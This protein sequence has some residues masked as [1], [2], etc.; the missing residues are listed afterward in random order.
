MW[1]SENKMHYKMYKAGKHWMYSAI[2]VTMFSVATLGG[3]LLLNNNHVHADTNSLTQGQKTNIGQISSS[4]TQENTGSD[5]KNESAT[6]DTAVTE[7]KA[8]A[9]SKNESVANDNAAAKPEEQKQSAATDTAATEE[10]AV[11]DSKNE[12]VANDNAAVKSKEQKQAASTDTAATEEKAGTDS[13]NESAANDNAA[14]KPEEQKQPVATTPAAT[15]EKAGTDSKNESVA[16]DNAAAKPEEQKQLVA[17]IPAATEEKAVTDSKN[18]SATSDNTAAKPEEQKQSAATD[19]T[20]AEEK[21][22]T[23]SNNES[24]TRDNTATKSEA[25]TQAATD[26]ENDYQST[27]NAQDVDNTLESDKFKNLEVVNST[28]DDP[29]NSNVTKNQNVDEID[30]SYDKAQLRLAATDTDSVTVTT[31]QEFYDALTKGTAPTINVGANIDLSTLAPSAGPTEITMQNLRDNVV[32]Q[33]TPG[34]TYTVDLGPYAF[35]IQNSNAN[36]TIQNLKAFGRSYYGIIS[37]AGRYDL[38]NLDYTGSQLIY[39]PSADIYIHNKVTSASVTSYNNGFSGGEKYTQDCTPTSVPNRQQVIQGE[40]ITFTSGST[41]DASTVNGNVIELSSGGKGAVLEDN[42][43][44][45]LHPHGANSSGEDI[46]NGSA[47]A[48]K[49]SSANV[50]IGKNAALNIIADD[51]QPADKGMTAGAIYLS[52]TSEINIADNG[53]LNV[54]TDGQA[55]SEPI[56]LTNSSTM[57]VSDSSSFTYNGNNL[58]NYTGD[59]IH[60]DG[61]GIFSISQ[62]GNFQVNVDGNGKIQVF[63]IKN[64]GNFTVDHPGIFIVDTTKNT[65]SGTTML[66]NGS[67]KVTNAELKLSDGS[68]SIPIKSVTLYFQNGIVTDVQDLQ[69]IS[70]SEIDNFIGKTDILTN[71][72]DSQQDAD[73]QAIISTLKNNGNA[74]RVVEFLADTPSKEDKDAAINKLKNYG[75]AAKDKIA[76][77]PGLTP[78]EISDG[79]KEVDDAVNDGVNNIESSQTPEAMMGS[80]KDGETNIDKIVDGLQGTSDTNIKNAKQTASD[81]VD[82]AAKDAIDHINNEPNLTPDEKKDAVNKVTD[83]ANQAKD[84]INNAGSLDDI[85]KAADDGITKITNDQNAADLQNAKNEAKDELAKYGQATKDKIAEIPGLTSDQISSADSDI[86]KEVANGS[87][88]IDNASDIAGVK[89][90]LTTSEGNIDKIVD[91]QNAK[92]KAK[93]E[94]VNYGQAAKDKIAKMPGL[95]SDQISSADAAIDKEVANGSANIDNASDTAGVDSAL[96]TSEGNID[97]IVDS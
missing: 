15:E 86:D 33:S 75:Q 67:L 78:D 16:N 73:N 54:E 4:I 39:S 46:S 96:T 53:K 57:N 92:N 31:A 35:R 70:R 52:G 50:S 68:N 5:S 12:S 62:N 87:A 14:A 3:T 44:V 17:T 36:V 79:Q 10:K 13:K 93:G 88:N 49:A 77:M 11:T 80:L 72:D 82:N 56:Y 21:A 23:D 55:K 76:N 8:V 74:L 20:I 37:R 7:E 97:K 28:T 59:I 42:S 43:T 18:E 65:N 69:T 19:T 89:S 95:T 58:G 48:I 1:N 83:D 91:L 90:A 51:S 81:N 6:N 26:S 60:V 38:S 32:L 66:A 2:T 25:Q 63:G 41:F 64:S 27:D 94:L 34:E 61:T 9:D 22:G 30:D 85:K 24:V 84:Q 71:L 47:Y 45:T 40:S 29:N